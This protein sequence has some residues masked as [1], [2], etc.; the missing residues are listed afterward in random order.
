MPTGD[1]GAWQQSFTADLDRRNPSPQPSTARVESSG[2]RP[3]LTVTREA[4]GALHT[5]VLGPDFFASA[6]YAR[7]CVFNKRGVLGEGA[8]LHRSGRRHT[9]A[10][11]SDLFEVLMA[12][13]RRGMQIQRYKGLGEM[14]PEQLH[15][16]TLD[17]GNRRLVQVR[18]EDAIAAD[19]M[20]TT[21]MGEQVEPR[22]EFIERHALLAGNIDV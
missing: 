13:T 2:E 1:A 18:V 17:P 12:D 14:N 9:V 5:T 20:F 21:L 7:M 10:A 8:E 22:R 4:H 19:Q 6:D 16:T 3:S 11:F 15:T